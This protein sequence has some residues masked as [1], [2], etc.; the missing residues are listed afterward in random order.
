MSPR[1]WGGPTALYQLARCTVRRNARTRRRPGW[2]GWPHGWCGR[3]EISGL[4]PVPRAGVGPVA[5]RSHRSGSRQRS[6]R[7]ADP[8]DGGAPGALARGAPGWRVPGWARARARCHP[9]RP[10]RTRAASKGEPVDDPTAVHEVAPSRE[11]ARFFGGRL[12]D[13][14]EQALTVASCSGVSVRASRSAA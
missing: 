14:S 12:L 3:R 1:L 6:S 2:P 8:I 9:R 10:G 13:S 5:S 11:G 4:E 7:L